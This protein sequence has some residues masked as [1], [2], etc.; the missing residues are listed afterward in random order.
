MWWTQR[1]GFTLVKRQA[2]P[3]IK[4]SVTVS[5]PQHVP[6]PCEANRAPFRQLN[7]TVAE[8]LANHAL[9]EI[10]GDMRCENEILIGDIRALE[11]AIHKAKQITQQQET[12]ISRLRSECDRWLSETYMLSEQ[13]AT[14]TRK[15]AKTAAE[16]VS[17]RR[18]ELTVRRDGSTQSVA[19]TGDLERTRLEPEESVDA[20][21][22]RAA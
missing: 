13:L 2:C 15:L 11:R 21:N 16:P 8:H 14:V 17:S 20:S 22:R 5:R 19:C 12:E 6:R 7:L 3:P 9:S 1:Q 10:H 4:R 18:T